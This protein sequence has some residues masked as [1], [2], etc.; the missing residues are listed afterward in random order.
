MPER[1]RRSSSG[2]PSARVNFDLRKR[3]S[4]DSILVDRT[5][6]VKA[7]LYVRTAEQ[8]L[9]HQLTQ[10]DQASA[11]F[12]M[13]SSAS[14][15][16]YRRLRLKPQRK[17]SARASPRRRCE[18]KE[19][20]GAGRTLAGSHRSTVPSSPPFSRWS[21]RSTAPQRLQGLPAYLA[22]RSCGCAGTRLGRP[23]SSRM[24]DAPPI[25]LARTSVGRSVWRSLRAL[26]G[27]IV[28]P[29]G[30]W[31]WEIAPRCMVVN[32]RDLYGCSS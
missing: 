13:R 7:V 20:S 5:S 10:A 1:T 18:W 14:W 25:V 15:P 4:G 29:S 17:R 3:S 31:S 21:G 22:R 27:R 16:P 11:P 32:P 28:V 9:D 2:G 26:L 12:A 24:E 19:A 23:S 30:R 6:I 8:N